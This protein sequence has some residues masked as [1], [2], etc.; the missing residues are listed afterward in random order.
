MSAK[1]FRCV[2]PTYPIYEMQDAR[3]ISIQAVQVRSEFR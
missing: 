2:G 3:G 1:A